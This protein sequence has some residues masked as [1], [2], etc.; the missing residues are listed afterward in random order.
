M[1]YF[2]KA[3]SV[4][5]VS[6]L[7]NYFLEIFDATLPRYHIKKRLCDTVTYFE[8]ATWDADYPTDDEPSPILFLVCPEQL[9]LFMPN[10]TC[11]DL[12]RTYGSEMIG[13]DC[14]YDLPQ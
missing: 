4:D 2:S 11:E 9:I 1:L 8:A 5:D 6:T 7:D 14:G 10:D 3:K 13:N 12:L